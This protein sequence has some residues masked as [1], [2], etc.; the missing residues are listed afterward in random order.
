MPSTP[1]EIG[2]K[3]RAARED[4]N[5]TL[6]DLAETCGLTSSEIKEVEEGTSESS[7]YAQ[8]IALSLGLAFD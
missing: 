5:Y 4:L 2:L 1:Q 7:S 6:E 8:R 3:L